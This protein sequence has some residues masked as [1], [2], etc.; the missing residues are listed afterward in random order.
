[1][2][3]IFKLSGGLIILIATTDNN[4]YLTRNKEFN[5]IRIYLAAALKSYGKSATFRQHYYP[6]GGWGWVVAFCC[7]VV[8]V[9]TYGLQLSFGALQLGLVEHVREFEAGPDHRVVRQ[10]DEVVVD[11]GG[12]GG[13]MPDELDV[14]KSAAVDQMDMRKKAG[15]EPGE[16]KWIDGWM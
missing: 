15:E 13:E 11:A 9:F 4:Y 6:E 16:E 3:A 14:T 10:L 12:E 2:K 1:M 8:N 7:F 5:L